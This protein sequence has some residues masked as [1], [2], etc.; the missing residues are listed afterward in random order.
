VLQKRINSLAQ[1]VYADD[2]EMCKQ[3]VF[4]PVGTPGD[5]GGDEPGDDGGGGIDLVGGGTDQ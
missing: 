2:Y 5:G 3:F 4:D 1:I